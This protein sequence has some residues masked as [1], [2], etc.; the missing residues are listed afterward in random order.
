MIV[1]ARID[2]SEDAKHAG[3]QLNPTKLII[4]GNPKGGTPLM[5][6]SPSVAIDFPLKIL[7]STDNSGNTWLSYNSLQYLKERHNIPEG[8]LKNISGIENIVSTVST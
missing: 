4:F 3:L 5:Q 1:F 2:F 7:V 8:L 6:A